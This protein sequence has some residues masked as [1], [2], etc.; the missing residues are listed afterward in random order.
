[1]CI[2]AVAP[3]VGARIETQVGN[4]GREPYWRSLPVR[5]RGLKFFH[6]RVFRC[7][8]LVIRSIFLLI[9]CS[10]CSTPH[11]DFFSH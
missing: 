6:V 2:I 10:G 4:V 11:L 1:M 8:D 9:L 5:E 7:Q 3:R